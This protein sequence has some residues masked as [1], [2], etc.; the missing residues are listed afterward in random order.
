MVSGYMD[1]F[2]GECKLSTLFVRAK[3]KQ[4]KIAKKSAKRELVRYKISNMTSSD[5]EWE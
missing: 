3:I 1:S 5:L 4:A 2:C